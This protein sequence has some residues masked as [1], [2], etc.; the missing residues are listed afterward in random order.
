MGIRKRK[1]LDEEEP[2]TITKEMQLFNASIKLSQRELGAITPMVR[3]QVQARSGGFCEVKKRC[4]GTFAVHMA[5]IIGRTHIKHRTTAVD[6]LH[7]CL[8]C[9]KWL[10]EDP[11]GIAYKNRL[12]EKLG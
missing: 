5:H 11:G 9:H 10:D 8:E 7:S 12:A 6:L 1:R 2:R 3:K 4:R